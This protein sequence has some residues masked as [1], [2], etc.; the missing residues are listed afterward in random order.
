VLVRN[1]F[2]KTHP[3]NIAEDGSGKAKPGLKA[4]AIDEIKKYLV[5]TLYLWVLFALFSLHRTLVL[6]HA[7]V[8]FQEQGLAIVNALIFAK[9][10]LI[11]DD[12]K[13]GSRFKNYPL[14]YSVLWRSAAFSIVLI[15]FHIVE[16][17]AIAWLRGKPLADS[18]AAFGSGDLKGV[19]A[20]GAIWFVTLI[21]FFM[22]AEI[23]RV[24]GQDKL[25]R[26]LL[27]RDR[28]SVSLQVRD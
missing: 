1:Q 2:T 4:R 28:K 25:W 14:I 20:F 21:P 17:A 23:D 24:L 7:H 16:G 18:L 27:A 11:A 15:C 6:E 19:V 22:F 10:M 13:L 9:V 3:I 26:L 5:I 8:D 12:L